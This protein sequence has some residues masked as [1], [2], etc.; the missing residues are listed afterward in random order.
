MTTSSIRPA[1]LLTLS[2]EVIADPAM[3]Q[4]AKD[5]FT[6]LGITRRVGT[7]SAEERRALRWAKPD[8]DTHDDDD[9][10]HDER[11]DVDDH[12]DEDGEDPDGDGIAAV[13]GAS[14]D[15]D[16]VLLAELPMPTL[17]DDGTV[18]DLAHFVGVAAPYHRTQPLG[19]LRDGT[20]LCEELSARTFRGRPRSR[21][22]LEHNPHRPVGHVS[23]Y[24]APDA[25]RADGTL[26]LD[27][28]E[29]RAAA[30]LLK[31][32]SL[33]GLSI[34]FNC[35]HGADK[36]EQRSKTVRVIHRRNAVLTGLSLV[37]LPAYA[38]ASRVTAYFNDPAAHTQ[39]R[40]RL[41][42]VATP[43]LPRARATLAAAHAAVRQYVAPDPR[44]VKARANIAA[45]RTRIAQIPDLKR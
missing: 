43:E 33:L 14:L 27:A 38:P 11:Q 42:D 44:Q 18:R 26:V 41:R 12:A 10:A 2:F 6:A 24:S 29:G 5:E 25:L 17:H 23:W 7:L 4:L 20:L 32:G 30:A 37:A 36:M 39:A 22:T 8:D 40:G 16:E 3:R 45:L 34:E 1:S 21:L 13:R 9:D 28:A 19:R 35:D 31:A 15:P